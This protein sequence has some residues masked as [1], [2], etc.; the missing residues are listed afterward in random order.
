[1]L[2]PYTKKEIVY[3]INNNDKDNDKAIRELRADLYD[4]YDDVQVY[5]NGLH[6]SRI[7]CT[8]K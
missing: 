1:M 7:I 5:P 4:T 3:Y 8:I 2:K 6:E